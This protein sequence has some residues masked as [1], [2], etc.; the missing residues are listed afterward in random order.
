MNRIWIYESELR[1]IAADYAELV[2]RNSG[3]P[4][5]AIKLLNR[6][7]IWQRITWSAVAPR[8]RQL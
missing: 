2:Q 4:V 1:A 3:N 5:L 7:L 6:S 8:R